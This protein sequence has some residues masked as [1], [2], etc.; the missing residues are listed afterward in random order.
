MR[1]LSVIAFLFALLLLVSCSS[2]EAPEPPPPPPPEP[3]WLWVSVWGEHK[4]LGFDPDQQKEGASGA[5]AAIVVN[6]GAGRAPYGMDFDADGNLWVGTQEG[7]LLAYAAEDLHQSGAPTPFKELGTGAPHVAGVRFAPNGWLWAA[8]QGKVLGWSP[9]RLTAAGKPE[10][11]VT[12]TSASAYMPEYPNDLVF[13]EDGNMWLVGTGAVLMFARSQLVSS[14]AVMPEVVIASD[15]E[16]LNGVMGLAFDAG[17]DLWVTAYAG[18]RIERFARDDLAASGTPT[19]AVTL[20]PPGIGPMRLAFDADDG[21]WVTT[22][23]TPGFGDFGHMAMIA[24]ADREVSGPAPASVEMTPLGNI[25]A[26]G[27]IVFHPRP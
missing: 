6:L 5:Q 8:V 10:P 19:P 11:N 3:D 14:G 17:G 23:F 20:S 22:V 24:P 26:G 25:D 15:G 1:H 7:E 2:S 21:L 16:S 27:T 4:V 12:L 13:D 18:G 9:T